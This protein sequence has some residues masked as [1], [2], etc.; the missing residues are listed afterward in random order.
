MHFEPLT[1]EDI[2]RVRPYFSHLKSNTCDY[3]TGVLF[4]W[5]RYYQMKR[6]FTEDG[7]FSKL[8]DET[9]A[10][11]YNLPLAPDMEQALQKLYAY[12]YKPLR[13][14]TVPEAYLPMLQKLF[15]DCS[16]QEQPEFFDYLYRAEDLIGLHGKKFSGQRN[17][18]SQFKR[19]VESWRFEPLTEQ[20][21]EQVKTFFQ[22]YIDAEKQAETAH[23]EN[24]IVLEVLEHIDTYQM[25]GG[26]LYA[27]DRVVGFT[28]GEILGDTLYIHIEK[29]DRNVK[30]AYQMVVNQAAM[31]FCT[32]EIAFI[33]REDDM[34]D[35]GLRTAKL[36]YHPVDILK[37]YIVTI[38]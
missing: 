25:L 31:S 19:S 34:G 38:P 16:V 30:G 33:N 5:R 35:P 22:T 8:H 10:K 18:I 9:G 21:L 7:F 11:Y 29:A 13:F 2:D 27:D 14:C 1:L 17:Q 12:A 32:P 28:L 4:M 36:A 3:T 24:A 6:C 37:K 15:P 23:A 26:V 20:N